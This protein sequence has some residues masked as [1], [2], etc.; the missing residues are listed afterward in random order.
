M[1]TPWTEAELSS[2]DSWYPVAGSAQLVKS[3]LSAYDLGIS[4]IS[5]RYS[6]QNKSDPSTLL[7]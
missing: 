5:L 2:L 4:V 1:E 6:K 3:M 7:E